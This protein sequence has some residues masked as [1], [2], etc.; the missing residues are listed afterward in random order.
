M[1]NNLSNMVKGVSIGLM[2]G[3]AV[4]FAGKKMI[5]ENPKMR[6]KANKAVR[7]VSSLIDTAQYMLK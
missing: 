7:T 5:D 4:G 2:A 3:V 1:S 6:K